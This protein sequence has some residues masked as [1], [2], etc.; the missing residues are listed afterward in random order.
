VRFFIWFQRPDLAM[1]EIVPPFDW[2]MAWPEVLKMKFSLVAMLFGLCLLGRAQPVGPVDALYFSRNSISSIRGSSLTWLRP[3]GT[4]VQLFGRSQVSATP[5]TY[6]SGQA[7]TYSLTVS[8]QN[9]KWRTLRFD[10]GTGIGRVLDFETFRTPND[11]GA[12]SFTWAERSRSD[13]VVNTSSRALVTID[14]PA[15]AGFVLPGE[16]S[17]WVVFRGI[18]PALATYGVDDALVAPKL[19]VFKGSAKLAENIGWTSIPEWAAGLETV[20]AMVG[21]FPLP[22]GSADCAILLYLE[23]GNYT[24]QTVPT[25]GQGGTTLTEVYLLPFGN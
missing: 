4:Y 21:A 23:P 22:R 14:H 5:E 15:I 3:D 18:G 7:G 10:A 9:T 24:V 12:F 1:L 8:S 25:N 19:S 6:S 11:P 20:F 17:R 16:K 13:A 2:C